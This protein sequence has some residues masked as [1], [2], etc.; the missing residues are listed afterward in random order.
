MLRHKLLASCLEQDP[1]L[2]VN[3]AHPTPLNVQ[4]HGQAFRV[5]MRWE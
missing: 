5:P 2:A 4:T 3:L 1:I